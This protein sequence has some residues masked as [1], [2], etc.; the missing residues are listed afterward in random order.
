MNQW[1]ER[2]QEFLPSARV[3]KIQATICD[4]EDKDIVIGMV[5][6][7]YNKEFPPEVYSE[8]GFTIVDEVHRISSEQCF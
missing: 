2:I 5:Q 7:L 6:T 4:I 1:I 8:F 3:G